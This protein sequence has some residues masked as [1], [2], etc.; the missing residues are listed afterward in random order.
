VNKTSKWRLSDPSDLTIQE[1]RVVELLRVGK[2]SRQIAELMGI[3]R[4]TLNTYC[5]R[6]FKK[7]GTHHRIEM[8]AAVPPWS[9]DMVLEDEM[10]GVV[11][12]GQS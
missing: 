1:R 5:C 12:R 6:I 7:T 10:D 3:S 11:E 2:G 9:P 4:N 8:L